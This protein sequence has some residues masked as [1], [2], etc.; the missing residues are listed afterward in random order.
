VFVATPERWVF[1]PRSFGISTLT[2][3]SAGSQ[4][5]GGEHLRGVGELREHVG[6]AEA[7]DLDPAQAAR[8]QWFD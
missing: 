1:T 5:H 8:A 4:P 3:T 6:A 2:D 7:R